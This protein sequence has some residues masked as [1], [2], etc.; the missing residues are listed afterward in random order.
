MSAVRRGLGP[1]ARQLS[2]TPVVVRWLYLQLLA[3]LL[4]V[5]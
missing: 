5:A 2:P 1:Y 4:V 3:P